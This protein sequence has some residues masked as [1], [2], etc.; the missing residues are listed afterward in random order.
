MWPLRPQAE[1]TAYKA[2]SEELSL[3]LLA[4]NQLAATISSRAADGRASSV[5]A[6]ETLSTQ[7]VDT[8]AM[9]R[10]SDEELHTAEG[11]LEEAKAARACLSSF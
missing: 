7:L 9:L 5:V 2:R 3:A 6:E 11:L 8:L 10:A 1:R 4:S